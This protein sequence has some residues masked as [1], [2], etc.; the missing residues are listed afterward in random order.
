[1]RPS[2]ED[3]ALWGASGLDRARQ[4]AILLASRLRSAPRGRASHPLDLGDGGPRDIQNSGATFVAVGLERMNPRVNEASALWRTGAV[5]PPPSGWR[6]ELSVVTD[7]FEGSPAKKELN[8]R[9]R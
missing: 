5:Q 6:E 2:Q 7:S 9:P 4:A 3:A 1:M 8:L